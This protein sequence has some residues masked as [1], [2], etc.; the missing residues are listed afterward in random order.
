MV[1]SRCRELLSASRS[2]T[3]PFHYEAAGCSV[4][5]VAPGA[6]DGNLPM[7]GITCAC[8]IA[9]KV[10]P[11]IAL[12]DAAVNAIP[13]RPSGWQ[14]ERG[15]DDRGGAVLCQSRA[16]LTHDSQA[17]PDRAVKKAHE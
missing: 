16:V 8:G 13:A 7:H 6:I 2:A 11:P 5:S 3:L 9:E 10:E 1:L 14:K 12:T 15:T 4:T 17:R